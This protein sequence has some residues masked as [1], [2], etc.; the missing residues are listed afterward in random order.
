MILPFY[1]SSLSGAFLIREDLHNSEGGQLLLST[2]A[3]GD[4][5]PNEGV[6]IGCTSEGDSVS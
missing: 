5:L 6:V 1:R 3:E 4:P 2:I